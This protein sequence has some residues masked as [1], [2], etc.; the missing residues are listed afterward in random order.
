MYAFRALVGL[1]EAAF[2]PVSLFLL[3]SWYT[4]PELA[5][6]TAFWMVSGIFGSAISGYLQAAIY[7]TLD[8][9]AGFAGVS[10][11]VSHCS[12]FS[13]TMSSGDGSTSSAA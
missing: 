8:G 4:G 10:P 9:V 11:P 1:F 3:A 12:D 7:V 13:L 6:R 5:K 2:Q